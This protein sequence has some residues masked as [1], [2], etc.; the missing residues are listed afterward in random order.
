MFLIMHK[1]FKYSKH[2][3]YITLESGKHFPIFSRTVCRENVTQNGPTPNRQNVLHVV[4]WLFLHIVGSSEVHIE[5]S[6]NIKK[7]FRLCTG[8]ST[9]LYHI[10]TNCLD[11]T[12]VE[13]L[14][15]VLNA[16][17]VFNNIYLQHN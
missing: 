3:H 6:K 17:I 15:L 2:S 7:D 13:G 11:L 5:L 4:I 9:E 1:E 14:V 10:F 8:T 16:Y 12:L